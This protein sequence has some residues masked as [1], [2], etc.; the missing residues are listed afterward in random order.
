MPLNWI[1]CVQ[2]S[3]INFVLYSQAA[4]REYPLRRRFV[5]NVY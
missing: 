2:M 3:D 5:Y 4:V 1:N